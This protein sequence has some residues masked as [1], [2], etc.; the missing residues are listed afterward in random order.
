MSHLSHL[1]LLGIQGTTF[2]P[3]LL[4]LPTPPHLLGLHLA[5]RITTCDPGTL[6]SRSLPA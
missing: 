1:P 6:T 3:I 5:L 4:P 2:L